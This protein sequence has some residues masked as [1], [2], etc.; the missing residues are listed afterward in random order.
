MAL[1]TGIKECRI[2]TLFD[3]LSCIALDRP[4]CIV[5]VKKMF[6]YQAKGE[7][8]HRAAANQL[9]NLHNSPLIQDFIIGYPQ[10]KPYLTDTLSHGAY[11][12]GTLKEEEKRISKE[13]EDEDSAHMTPG[14]SVEQI[15]ERWNLIPGVKPCKKI[16]GALLVKIKKLI[17]EHPPTWWD[18]LFTEIQGS[19]FLT[20]KAQGR[21]GKKPF[22]VDLDWATG[23]INFGK[24]LSG[25]YVD[26]PNGAF[27]KKERLPL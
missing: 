18:E 4:R 23:P 1:E 13:D 21:D 17:K 22:Q 12:F 25:K 14:I 2:D 19:A 5:W 27:V 3:T 8:G 24:I 7:K 6:G 11:S 16:E 10:V 9:M 26:G 20:G 15:R